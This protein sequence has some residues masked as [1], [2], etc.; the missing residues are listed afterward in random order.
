MNKKDLLQFCRYY[1]GEAS[2]PFEG[3]DQNK[4]SLWDYERFWIEQNFTDSGRNTLAEYIGDY[5]SV[6]LSL[7]EMQDDTPA[8]L[9]A[10][11]FNR[12][13]YWK[14]GSMADC[15]EPFKK[16]YHQYYK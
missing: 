5:A 12:Y 7:F 4:A 16:F 8:S 3:K 1:K 9:K 15:V 13:C 6:G 11:L 10:L 14:S 2:N